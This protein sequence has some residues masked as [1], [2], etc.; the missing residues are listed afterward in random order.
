[1]LG[2]RE[3]VLA[4]S[5]VETKAISA[6]EGCGNGLSSNASG[7]SVLFNTVNHDADLAAFDDVGPGGVSGRLCRFGFLP[8]NRGWA[9]REPLG[10]SGRVAGGVGGASRCD[11]HLFLDNRLTSLAMMMKMLSMP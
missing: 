5:G 9:S 6:V 3:L 8:G 1:V 2:L 10:S 11:D 4:L 7:I